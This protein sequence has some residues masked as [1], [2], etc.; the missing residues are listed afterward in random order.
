M[1]LPF[2]SLAL[3]ILPLLA[4]SARAAAP[5]VAEVNRR[6]W[7][8]AEY[9][10]SFW[11]GPPE[12]F[13][14][15]KRFAEIREAGFTFVTPPCTAGGPHGEAA[16]IARNRSMLDLAQKAGLKVFIADNRMPHRM[17]G[18][19]AKARI[20]AIVADYRD[21]PALA[22]YSVKDEPQAG[23]FADLGEVVSALREADPAHPAYINLLP[24]RPGAA[25]G[26]PSYEEYLR[27]FI[28]T[29]HPFT[30]SYDHYTF[31]KGGDGPTFVQNLVSARAASREKGIPFWNIVL[32]TEHGP[33][34]NLTEPEL[35]YEAMQSLA[36][37]AK[38]LLWFTYWTPVDA[39]FQWLHAPIGI[40]GS[41]DPHY[42][43]LKRIN[44]ELRA[45]GSAL[46]NADS[47]AV[48]HTGD[49]PQGAAGWSRDYPVRVVDNAALTVGLFTGPGGKHYAL[50]ANPNYRQGVQ[51]TLAIR[52]R[53]VHRM[54]G[55]SRR[56]SPAPDARRE[57]D[58]TLVPLALAPAEAALLR[59]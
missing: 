51:A 57:A 12:G 55:L 28:D 44:W 54:S 39:S 32:V 11:C 10:I 21:H 46:L 35:R 2:F 24:Y 30:L 31:T 45:Y 18:R 22:G 52:A 26:A 56:W 19:N 36:Y 1:K 40:D 42:D 41:R 4:A 48:F 47:T 3:A 23:E 15:P 6:A 37:G 8:P 7:Q 20:E 49:V 50:A 33:Y 53:S 34:R 27:N 25:W 9:P 58:E 5:S 38:G 14:T 17:E 43:M 13:L 16:T 29:V 59:W